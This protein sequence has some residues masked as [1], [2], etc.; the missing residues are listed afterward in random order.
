MYGWRR[1]L[2]R[3]FGTRIGG[4]VIIRPTATV[5]YPW[6]VAI[7]DF[8]WI[9][10]DVVLYSLGD[11]TVGSHSMISQRSYRCGGDHHYRDPCFSI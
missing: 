4:G 8:C 6:K 7:G 2:L 9:G 5:T 3:A 1:W 11:L 10:D